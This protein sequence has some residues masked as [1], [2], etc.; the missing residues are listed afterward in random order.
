MEAIVSL[1]Y[2]MT[3]HSLLVDYEYGDEPKEKK[4]KGKKTYYRGYCAQI[5]RPYREQQINN[6]NKRIIQHKGWLTNIMIQRKN[7]T[8]D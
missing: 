2:T 6:N 4:Q 7:I 1:L 5:T 8:R 3:T